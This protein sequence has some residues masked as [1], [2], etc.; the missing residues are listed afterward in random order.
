MEEMGF[1]PMRNN[2]GLV[3]FWDSLPFK[4][5]LLDLLIKWAD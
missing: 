4:C 2:M 5:K 3:L 1:V